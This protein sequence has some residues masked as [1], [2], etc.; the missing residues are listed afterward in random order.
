[1]NTT[2]SYEIDF[3]RSMTDLWPHAKKMARRQIVAREHV[4]IFLLFFL[5]FSFF[6]L[7]FK[8]SRL[9]IRRIDGRMGGWV[10]GWG[11]GE[12]GRTEC[13]KNLGKNMLRAVTLRHSPRR[14]FWP[15]LINCFFPFFFFF[16]KVFFSSLFLVFFIFSFII[17]CI[18][19]KPQNTS[20]RP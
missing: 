4:T 1:M 2:R 7:T 6:S 10:G 3:D 18:S 16:F 5:R 11:E 12:G 13:L 9:S 14:R 19:F 20:S 8:V 15:T 17:S